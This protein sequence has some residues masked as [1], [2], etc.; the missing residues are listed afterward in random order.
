MGPSLYILIRMWQTIESFCVRERSRTQDL[1]VYLV[2]SRELSPRP[3][4]LLHRKWVRIIRAFDLWMT[5]KTNNNFLRAHFTVLNSAVVYVHLNS[6]LRCT[7]CVTK[8]TFNWI[9][10]FF[11]VYLARARWKIYAHLRRYVWEISDR[12]REIFS[13]V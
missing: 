7:A 2:K 3:P 8:L 11:L 6:K 13:I 4:R 12:V 1:S 10:N 9:A 5:L